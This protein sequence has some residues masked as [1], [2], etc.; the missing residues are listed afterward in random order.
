MISPPGCCLVNIYNRQ[1]NDKLK[2]ISLGDHFFGQAC[3]VIYSFKPVYLTFLCSFDG[4]QKKH[5]GALITEKQVWVN[6]I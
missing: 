2:S 4:Y 5:I 1:K 3:L 6:R